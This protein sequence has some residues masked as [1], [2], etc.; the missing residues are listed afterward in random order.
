MDDLRRLFPPPELSPYFAARVAANLPRETARPAPR[1]M[2]LYWAAL[3]V[4]TLAAVAAL[5]PP[6]WVFYPAV[7]LSFVVVCVPRRSLLRCV[8]PF[9]R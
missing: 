8:A 9:L 4:A 2:R 6:Q 3:A 1:W 5:D 7:P